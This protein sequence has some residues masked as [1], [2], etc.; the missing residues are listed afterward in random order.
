MAWCD[1]VRR[2]MASARRTVN[3]SPEAAEAAV[4]PESAA[5]CHSARATVVRK[6]SPRRARD[7]RLSTTKKTA[8]AA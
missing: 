4:S 7:E 8:N 6:H 3:H 2:K 1:G 5:R